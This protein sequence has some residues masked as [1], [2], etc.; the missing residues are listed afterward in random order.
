MGLQNRPNSGARTS[1]IH[2][3]VQVPHKFLKVYLYNR[4]IKDLE[5]SL[6]YTPK[7][8]SYYA[9]GSRN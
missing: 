5:V 8:N 2:E 7:A 9:S 3:L 6:A 1:S 4:N